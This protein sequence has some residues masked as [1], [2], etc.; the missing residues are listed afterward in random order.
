[1]LA[2]LIGKNLLARPLRYLLTGLAIVFGVAAVTAVFIF[3][4]GL[5]TTFD[6]LGGNIQAGFDISIQNDSPFGDGADVPPVPIA[7]ADELAQIDGIASVQPRMLEFGVVPV[8]GDGEALIANGPNLGINWESRTPNPR[9]FVKEGRE[10]TGAN[11]FAMDIDGFDSGAFVV[12]DTYSILAPTGTAQMQL[13]GTF[14]FGAEEENASVGAVLLAFEEAQALDFLNDGEGYDDIAIV[15]DGAIEDVR[16]QI[17]VLLAAESPTLVAIDQQELIQDAQDNFGQILGIFQTILL[18]FAAIILLVSAFLIFNVFTI[19]LGQRIKELGLLRSI[20]AFGSQITQMMLGEA[21]ILGALATI[22]GMP[23]GWLLARLLRFGLSQLG[24]PGD[25]GLPIQPRTIIAALFV[26]IVVTMLAA[27]FPSIKARQVTPMA[28]LREGGSIDTLQADRNLPRLGIGLALGVLALVVAFAVGSWLTLLLLPI[29]SGV[30]F[31]V[32]L[33]YLGPG[34]RQTAQIATLVFG[35]VLL[36]VVRVSD[37]DVGPTFGLLGAGALLTILGASQVSSLF[38]TPVAR[39][40]GQPP[41][42]VIV[43]IIGIAMGAGAIG[44]LVYGVVLAVD[45]TAGGSFLVIGAFVLGV[46]SYGLVRTARGA[47][48]LTGQLARENAA[49][50]PSRTATTATALMVGLALVT[51]VTVIGDSIKSSVTDALG[52]SITADWFIQGP[53]NGPQGLPFSTDAA[54]IV[55]DL[56]EIGLVVP[57]RFGFSSFVSLQ[58]AETADVAQALP[59]LFG[60]IGD[61]DDAPAALSQ[62]ETELGV[63]NL[64]IDDVLATDFATVQQHINA[65]FVELDESA[66]PATS[67]WIEDGVASDR[68]LS[69][70]DTFPVVFLDASVVELTVTGIYEDGFV[71]GDRVIDNAL[72]EQHLADDS[73]TF[74]SASTTEGA[75]PEDAR[76]AM[77]TALVADYPVLDVQD[78]AEVQSEAEAQINQTLATVNVL[79]LLSAVT[80]ILGIAIALSLAVFERTREIGLLRAVG[81]TRQQTRWMVRWEGVIVAAFG[82][83]VG[84]VVGVGLGILATQKMPEFLVN[85]TSVPIP[86]LLSYVIIAAITGLGAGAF[87]A[88]IAGRM[89]VLDAI[90]NE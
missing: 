76:A 45:G 50:N 62:I 68:N 63:T 81:T 32:A 18:V 10:P 72:W 44:A 47:F 75:E 48:G 43:G 37:L 13:V 85:T 17:E 35:L 15:L 1:M 57:Y 7:I 89:N 77:T 6:E 52:N 66:D 2:T 23:A 71:F 60:A 8:D 69:M 36:T 82:G 80:A 42:A 55:D 31:Y 29:V 83:L 84:V 46:L 25:T 64:S 38:A 73:Y 20:G 40:L 74:I 88:W 59:T 33:R 51:G 24:F 79:L 28:A 27:L 9:L 53:Q 41:L 3:T 61:R 16:A 39:I 34:G 30:L 12:G 56:D 78:K 26:G 19:T 14:S 67:I 49:R 58:G 22:V 90:S 21:F 65:D 86:Q 70:G 11:E 54:Q 4:D 5:R 87:P